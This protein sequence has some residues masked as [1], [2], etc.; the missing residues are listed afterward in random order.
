MPTAEM[1]FKDC[2]RSLS[3][4]SLPL[5]PGFWSCFRYTS[6]SIIGCCWQDYWTLAKAA[7][8]SKAPSHAS[9]NTTEC[10]KCGSPLSPAQRFVFSPDEE[11]HSGRIELEASAGIPAGLC[12]DGSCPVRTTAIFQSIKT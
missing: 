6:I 3:L 8:S 10:T 12:L 11:S 4:S 2:G 7:C 9:T 1:R 5:C